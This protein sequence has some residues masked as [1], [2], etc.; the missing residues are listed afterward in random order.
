MVILTLRTRGKERRESGQRTGR[1]SLHD[2]RFKSFML[3][4]I[5]RNSDPIDDPISDPNT[6]N[7]ETGSIGYPQGS[8]YTIKSVQE[9]RKVE[10][11]AGRYK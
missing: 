5:W 3:W 9:R 11:R 1:K 6:F 7:Q 4:N 8:Q 10:M 2:P